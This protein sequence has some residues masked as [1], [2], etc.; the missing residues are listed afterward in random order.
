M[1]G[2]G[3]EWKK[4]ACSAREIPYSYFMLQ[5]HEREIKCTQEYRC[6]ARDRVRGGAPLAAERTGHTE[7]AC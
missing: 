3:S 6:S 7:S 2:C 4:P 1:P 5:P